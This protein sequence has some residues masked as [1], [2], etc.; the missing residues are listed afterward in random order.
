MQKPTRFGTIE[1]A[2]RIWLVG[3]IHGEHA[4]LV[5]VTMQLRGHSSQET[6]WSTWGITLAWVTEVTKTLDELLS[7]R[8]YMMA[9]HW[10]MPQDLQYL[11]ARKKKCGTACF[12]CISREAHKAFLN[13]CWNED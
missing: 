5:A 7:F 10:L 4:R 1:K 6:D 9:R 3:S 12:S 8:R 2:R 13:G 11:E